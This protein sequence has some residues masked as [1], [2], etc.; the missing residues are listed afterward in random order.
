MRPSLRPSEDGHPD[1]QPGSCF[2]PQDLDLDPG[3]LCQSVVGEKAGY[4]YR[5]DDSMIGRAQGE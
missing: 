1:G 3:K 2:S 4:V 5:A